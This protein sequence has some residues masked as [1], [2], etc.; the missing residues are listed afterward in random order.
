MKPNYIQYGSKPSRF[1]NLAR[2]LS[3]AGWKISAHCYGDAVAVT[4]SVIAFA[5]VANANREARTL[6]L[7]IQ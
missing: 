4:D 3:R 7:S 2:R 5:T 1:R 6:E